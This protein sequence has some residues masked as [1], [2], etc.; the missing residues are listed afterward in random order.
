MAAGVDAPKVTPDSVVEAT[1]AALRDGRPEV[2]GDDTSRF[3]KTQLSGD[4]SNLYPVLL[5]S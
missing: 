1:L 2:L 4:V 3:V 5:P